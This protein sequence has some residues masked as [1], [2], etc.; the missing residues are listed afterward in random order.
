MVSIAN[1][2]EYNFRK[3]IFKVNQK[4]ND[5]INSQNLS[6]KAGNNKFST[7][8]D[9]E[10]AKLKGSR[11]MPES[12][13]RYA[14][15]DK[16]VNLPL[17][18]DWVSAGAVTPVKDQGQCGSCWAFS[19]TGALEGIHFIKSGTLLS[20]SEQQ[21]VDCSTA[22]YGCGGGWQSEAF[23]YYE[24][25]FAEL[26][27]VYPYTAVDGTCM[28]NQSSTTAVDVSSYLNVNIDDVAAMKAAVAQQPVSVSLDAGHLFMN[29]SSGVLDSTK[30]GTKLDHAVLV[31]GYG[32]DAPTGLE[33]W[34]VKNS[35]GTSWGEEGYIRLAIIDEVG[36]CGVQMEPLYPTS[37]E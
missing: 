26:E 36:V 33:Y 8:T 34:T 4:F 32:I 2:E 35:W 19:S 25:N 14:T 15:F 17:T 11:M 18:I 9:S 10:L 24:T 37:N 5:E 21:L 16:N 23:V 30:C 7:W 3:E 28:Y 6:W 31:V 20:F 29:Y 22:N 12:K 13:K 1:V 27:S